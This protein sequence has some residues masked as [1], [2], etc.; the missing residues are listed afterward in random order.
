MK[1]I[2]R[3]RYL[4]I[5]NK[6]SGDIRLSIEKNPE[7]ISSFEGGTS[8]N[9]TLFPII[10]LSINRPSSVD[11]NGMKVKTPWNPNDSIGMTKYNLPVF[12]R[13]IKCIEKDLLIPDI[14]HYVKDRLEVNPDK[15]ESVRR[16]FM[17]GNTTIELS[18]VVINDNDTLL[19]GIKMKF[20]NEN[21]V[22]SLTIN[23]LR[24]LIF[25][26]EH[27]DVDSITLSLY[28]N[29]GKDPSK[30]TF[31]Q[32]NMIDIIPPKKLDENFTTD[33]K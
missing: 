25:N 22:T 16:V 17:I 15:Y 23:E 13:E 1:H 14:Y 9:L 11:E 18:P 27:L 20:N 32:S 19:E 10:S 21:S 31:T 28:F 6:L 2:I 3:Y 4:N 5:P 24:S 30:K 26:L 12:I 8:T 29:Y 7:Y 33:I